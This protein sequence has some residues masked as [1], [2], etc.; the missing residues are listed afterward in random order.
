MEG[1][2][3]NFEHTTTGTPQQ[4]VYVK[5]AIPTIMG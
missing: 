1:L 5:K 3:I 2:G 4:N